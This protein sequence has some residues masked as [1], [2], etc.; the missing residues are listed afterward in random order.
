MEDK[1][2]FW[3]K[4]LKSKHEF[5]VYFFDGPSTSAYTA[6]L[7]QGKHLKGFRE[8]IGKFFKNQFNLMKE[9]ERTS[10]QTSLQKGQAFI[11]YGFHV[12]GTAWNVVTCVL[13]SANN[14]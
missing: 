7:E 14:E 5:L 2:T 11:I 1:L 8:K 10:I 13:Y 6:K 3:N 12:K 9:D 4:E